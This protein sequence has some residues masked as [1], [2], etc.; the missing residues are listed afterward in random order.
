[1]KTLFR[2][3][4]II[5]PLCIL[6]TFQNCKQDAAPSEQEVVLSALTGVT[7]KVG[8]VTIDGVDKNAMYPGLTVSF[9]ASTFSS[10][11]GKLVWPAT[12]TW[13]FGSDNGRILVRDDGIS[14]SITDISDS[15]LK[16][17]LSWTKTTLD[18]GRPASLRGAHVFT[19]GK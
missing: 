5:V 16:L 12:G 6:I 10:T 17:A 15:Q 8:A 3:S 1:M 13:T 9:A 4:S 19:F 7:W 18:A 11:N 14:V 2:S